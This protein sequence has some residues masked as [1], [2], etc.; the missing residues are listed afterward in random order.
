MGNLNYQLLMRNYQYN[1]ILDIDNCS[2]QKSEGDLSCDLGDIRSPNM[3][4][5]EPLL[6]LESAEVP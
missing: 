2:Y 6:R 3:N 1:A 5:C 4:S